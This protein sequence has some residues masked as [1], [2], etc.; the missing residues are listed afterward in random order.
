M[1]TRIWTTGMPAGLCAVALLA[2]CATPPV[3]TAA[4]ASA[5]TDREVRQAVTAAVDDVT[6]CRLDRAPGSTVKQKICET[7]RERELR[8]MISANQV[9]RDA[10]RPLDRG[11]VDGRRRC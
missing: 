2:G 8:N 3:Q 10:S 9:F 1:N 5:Q 6:I 7:E 11:C 4:Q